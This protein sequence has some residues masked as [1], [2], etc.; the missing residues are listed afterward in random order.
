MTYENLI[1][2]M[3]ES[4]EKRIDEITRKA[5]L[6]ADEIR[7]AAEEKAESIKI[8]YLTK[9]QKSVQ[10]ER[11]KLIY[12]AKAESKMRIIK[13]KEQVIQRAFIEAK[14]RLEGFRNDS[15]YEENFK[16]M[17][18][19]AVLALEAER[20]V[21][22]IDKRDESLC[23]QVL[24]ELHH[25]SE[26][27]NDLTSLGGLEVSTKDGKIVVFNTIESRLAN[28]EELLRRHIFATLYGG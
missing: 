21:F 18:Q 15:N 14:K 23:K 27:V 19:E 28:A 6:E 2:S 12:Q 26:S 16:K 4:A 13:E 20:V 5:H 11:N 22:H 9:A 25:N 7:R 24:N 8:E 3:E 1:R 17:L 10:T